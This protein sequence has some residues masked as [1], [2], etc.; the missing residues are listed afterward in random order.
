MVLKIIFNLTGNNEIGQVTIK[1]GQ[2]TKK[3]RAG[4]KEAGQVTIKFG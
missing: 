3:S 2:V 1:F 4:K